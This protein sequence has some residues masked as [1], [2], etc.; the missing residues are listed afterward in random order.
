[1]TSLQALRVLVVEDETAIAIMI[2]DM[3]ADMG[4]V[5][6]GSV[7]TIE[8]ALRRIDKGGFDFALLDLNLG[9]RSAQDVADALVAKGIPFAFGSGYGRAGLPAHLKDRPVLQKP[10]LSDDLERVLRESLRPV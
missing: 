5:V 4:C 2:E 10:F 1:M 9:G 7:G 6:A 8:D 3:L